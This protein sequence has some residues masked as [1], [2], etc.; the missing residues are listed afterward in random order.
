MF[1][2]RLTLNQPH[3]CNWWTDG[4][5]DWLWLSA[6]RV[7]LPIALHAPRQ[8][9]E[10][11][12]VAERHPQLGLIIGHMGRSLGTKDDPAFTDL[13]AL[14]ALAKYANVAVEASGAPSYSSDPY[15]Y[16]NIHRH[17]QQIHDAFGPH[18][19]FWGSDIT[20]MPCSYRQCV[21]MFTEELPWLRGD[22]K[23]LVMGRGLSEW[24]QC[25]A[26]LPGG[27]IKKP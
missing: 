2:L 22:D 15:P 21:T 8:M 9:E 3:Q 20:R 10:V 18:R 5:L 1:G 6:E 11:A 25:W 13:A 12:R 7:G 14:L 19:M 17:I 23:D 24:T 16:R 26:R 27:V 4:T